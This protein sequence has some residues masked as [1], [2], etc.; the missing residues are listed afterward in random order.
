MKIQKHLPMVCLHTHPDTHPTPDY[1]L[2]PQPRD[3]HLPMQAPSTFKTGTR[4]AVLAISHPLQ[5]RLG[6]AVLLTPWNTRSAFL[7][8]ALSPSSPVFPSKF[9]KI[10]GYLFYSL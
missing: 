9:F 6:Q 8:F 4:Q 10:K 7:A 5:Q 3:P 2:W 1:S